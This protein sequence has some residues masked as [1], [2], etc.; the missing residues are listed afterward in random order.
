LLNVLPIFPC[1][2]AKE[3]LAAHGFKS[4]RL[5]VK[6]AAWPLIGFPT[7]AASG[8]D[9]L[10]I[11][12]TGV[13]WFD[14]NFDALPQ[15]LAHQT[16]RG[17][18]LLFK[19]AP[20]LR[21]SAGRIAPGIDVRAQGGYAIYWP[22]EGLP[23]EDHPLCEWPEWLL[24]EA[25]EACRAKSSPSEY[26]ST[27]N[28]SSPVMIRPLVG[29]RDAL[30]KLDPI[31]WRNRDGSAEGY[32]RWF[33]LMIA[34]KAAGIS[35]ED[36]VE[37]CTRDPVYADDAT[38][39]E[40]KWDSAPAR[41]S[42][43]LMAALKQ[44]GISRSKGT[45]RPRG[46]LRAEVHL[47]SQKSSHSWRSR[48]AG[49]RQWLARHASEPDLFSASCLVAEILIEYGKPQAL[50]QELLLADCKRNGLA[51]LLGAEGCRKTIEKAFRHVQ[52]KA[53]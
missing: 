21:C 34:C 37:W 46:N 41:H 10:D 52:E 23:I 32:D 17:L 16:Q 30:F 48:F 8:I 25:R 11:D 1:N 44:A 2:A 38:K 45:S 9:V 36:W 14:R 7:G 20:G 12:P 49:I 15:T 39:I 50:A 28:P 3:P 40:R 18:H 27:F 33:Q 26:L 53:A 51:S 24:Q 4:A 5:N 29:A 6:H 42:G 13:S 47:R 19:Y 43:A 31:C 35:V 22:R